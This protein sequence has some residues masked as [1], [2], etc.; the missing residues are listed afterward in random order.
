KINWY[1]K[2]I[3]NFAHIAA[4]LH[5]VTNKTKAHR[6][7]FTWGPEQQVA[8]NEFKNLLTTYPLF[9]EYPDLSTTFVLTTD[10]S[11]IGIGGILRQDTIT[12]T[13]INYFKSRVLNDT[14][15]KYD[16]IERE[17]LA[18]YWCL[19][20][21][22]SYIGDS[23]IIIETD[24]EPLQ[25]FHKK[26]INN[27]RIIN[28]IFKLQD[29]LPEIIA[30]KYRNGSNNTAADYISRHFPSS[31]VISNS[32]ILAEQ[33]DDWSVGTEQWFEDLPKPQRLRF[34]TSFINTTNST[35][36]AVTTGVKAKLIA[37]SVPPT[38]AESSTTTPQSSAP[39][40]TSEYLPFDFS[41]SRIRFE[42]EQ[43]P[44]IQQI[45]QNLYHKSDKRNFILKNNVLYKLVSRGLTD[46]KVIYAPSKLIPEILLSHHDH[47]LSGHFGVEHTWF[48]LK[49][50]YYWLHMRTMI[51]SYI[52]SCE[53]CSKY[54]VDRHKPPGFLQ[55]IEPP[56]D[57]FQI[58]GMDWW[59]PAQTSIN[60]N[61][62]ILVI[63][64]RLSGY[65]FATASPT[66][67][68]QD[69]ARILLE[70]VI[71]VHGSP[72][73]AIT[74]QGTHFNNE[75]L[76]SIT[77]LIGCKH[78][79]STPYHPQTNGQTERWNST[80][81][82]QLAK[83]FNDDH[84]NW[85]TY[86][87]S[88]VYA[89]NNSV[90][91]SSGFTPYQLA[92]GRRPHHPFDPA[93]STF[94]LKKPHDYWAQIIKYRSIALKQA[95]DNIIHQQLLSKQRFDKNR[96]HPIYHINDLVWMKIFSNR[97]KFDARYTGP[98][99][100]VRVLSPVSYIVE[101]PDLRQFQVHSNNIKR[102]Y[103]R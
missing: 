40:P 87:P 64:D 2:I 91:H 53:Q 18:I 51:T 31:N 82:T 41:L 32:T 60:G 58:L 17:A 28:W 80:F 36:N 96:S 71:L 42:Q 61:R 52:K 84:N 37:Q 63:T 79:F 50:K 1:R 39:S 67:T 19:T 9:L 57:V 25:N 103:P 97:T 6:H 12:G 47:P 69:T 35:I 3:P 68:A 77:N 59:G 16:T 21:L 66:N 46:I 30:V 34:A 8:F 75:L 7:E 45:I 20:E 29:I 90:H 89:Y 13:K 22:R 86:L 70:E 23:D 78:I 10:A 92:F 94:Y 4:P 76:Q 93:R 5:K 49:K 99:R 83:F 27:K 102:V 73:I 54:N 85:D 33:T 26:Q 74:D 56:A 72:D 55:P 14:E 43:D 15:R 48:L 11:E 24:H 62:Y 98:V 38:S 101:D 95:K 65:V 100:I 88:I 44:V 81:V